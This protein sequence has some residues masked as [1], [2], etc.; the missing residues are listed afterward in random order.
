M[1]QVT[2]KEASFHEVFFVSHV[3][4]HNSLMAQMD[5]YFFFG[6]GLASVDMTSQLPHFLVAENQPVT[7]HHMY[8]WVG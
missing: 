1:F 2:A 4:S 5:F 6:R 3:S 8:L 7:L